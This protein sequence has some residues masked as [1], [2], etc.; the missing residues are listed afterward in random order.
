MR[1]FNQTGSRTFLQNDNINVYFDYKNKLKMRISCHQLPGKM[2]FCF[3]LQLFFFSQVVL[4]QESL[5]VL[6]NEVSFALHPLS[7][8]V[9]F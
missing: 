2:N 3:V 9:S 6:Y 4:E 7:R 1:D 5:L 8:F